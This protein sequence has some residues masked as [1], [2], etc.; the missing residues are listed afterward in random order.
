MSL[1]TADFDTVVDAVRKADGVVIDG[2]RDGRHH[3][4]H[5]THIA[6][7]VFTDGIFEIVG[8]YDN[9]NCSMNIITMIDGKPYLSTV[10]MGVLRYSGEDIHARLEDYASN[11]LMHVRFA[12]VTLVTEKV[13]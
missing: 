7:M 6:K 10:S 8:L 5:L 1:K 11:N 12:D 2:H 9:C 3:T 13:T 4:T